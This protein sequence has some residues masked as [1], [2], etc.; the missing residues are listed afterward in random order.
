MAVTMD[1]NITVHVGY[2]YSILYG[3]NIPNPDWVQ[4]LLYWD[5]LQ[6]YLIV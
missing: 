6:L 2:V 1:N 4:I 3:M 5:T